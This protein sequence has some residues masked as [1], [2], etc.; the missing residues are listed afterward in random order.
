MSTPYTTASGLHYTSAMPVIEG[1][2]VRLQTALLGIR[3]EPRARL[4]QDCALL[5]V[6]MLT[7]IVVVFTGRLL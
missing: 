3:H 4:W 2:A 6:A 7:L 1:D 5:A